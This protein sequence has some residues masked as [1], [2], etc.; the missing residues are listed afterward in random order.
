MVPNSE[1]CPHIYVRQVKSGIVQSRLGFICLKF[2][3][4]LPIVFLFGFPCW[5]TSFYVFRNQF[6][7]WGCAL[8][9]ISN[10]VGSNSAS[11]SSLMLFNLIVCHLPYYS[12]SFRHIV[13]SLTLFSSSATEDWRVHVL[14]CLSCKLISVLRALISSFSD[15]FEDP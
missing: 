1:V 8:F 14:I 9:N 13:R 5:V 4:H 6:S 2:H 15:L 11:S 7:P 10:T 12:K 3:H